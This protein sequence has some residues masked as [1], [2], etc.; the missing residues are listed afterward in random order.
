MDV[1]VEWILNVPVILNT[2]VHDSMSWHMQTLQ[3]ALIFIESHVTYCGVPTLPTIMHDCEIY[4]LQARYKCFH[5]LV[6]GWA[7][8]ASGKTMLLQWVCNTTEEACCNKR[9][10]LWLKS[11]KWRVWL[12]GEEQERLLEAFEFT[13]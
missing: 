5:I 11:D 6:I 8:A 13:E 4:D 3:Q 9:E 12:H 2:D 1:V 10:C 7:N